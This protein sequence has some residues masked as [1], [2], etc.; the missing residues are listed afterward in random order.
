MA[1]YLIADLDIP[2]LSALADYRRRAAPVVA[3]HGGRA[4]IRLGAVSVLEGSWR[5]TSVMALEFPTMAALRGCYDG[6][7]YR[8]LLPMRQRVSRANV[9]AVE[10]I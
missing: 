1:A 8:A 2:D 10:G 3:R 5:P 9:I 4:I 7:E 6:V